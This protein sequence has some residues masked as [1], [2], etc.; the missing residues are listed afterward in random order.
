MQFQN[1]ISLFTWLWQH[2]S[3]TSPGCATHAVTPTSLFLHGNCGWKKKKDWCWGLPIQ[4]GTKIKIFFHKKKRKK[5]TVV[6][7][8]LPRDYC[9][10]RN[11]MWRDI[12]RQN[13]LILSGGDHAEKVKQLEALG[14]T[15][16][17]LHTGPWVYWKYHQNKLQSGLANC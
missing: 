10:V 9:C 12:I 6:S 4:G 15:T 14:L 5:K 11:S 2:H 3:V 8:N 13:M 16:A 17:I 7:P 1:A